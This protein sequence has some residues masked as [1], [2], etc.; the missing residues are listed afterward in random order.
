LILGGWVR[1]MFRVAALLAFGAAGVPAGAVSLL[2]SMQPLDAS[3]GGGALMS[4]VVRADGE[5]LAGQDGQGDVRSRR[6]EGWRVPLA[7]EPADGRSPVDADFRARGPGYTVHVGSGGA[8][9]ALQAPEARGAVASGDAVGGPSERR[10]SRSAV[11]DSGWVRVQFAGAAER[12]GFV[13]EAPVSGRIHR[14]IGSDPARWQRNLQP[15]GRIRYRDVYPGIDVAYYGNGRELE[16][17]LI[18]APGVSP[19]AARV[20]FD[21]VKS[22]SVDAE[23]H[24]R[25]DTGSAVLVQR[26]PVAY[27]DGPRGRVRVEAAYRRHEDGTVGFEMGAVD[28]RLPLV[29]DPVLSYATLVGG[30]G[31]DACWDVAV[32]AAGAAYVVGETESLNFSGTSIASTN[33]LLAGYQGGLSGVAGDAFVGKLAPDGSA[34]EWLTYLG[35]SDLETAFSVGVASN[36]EP[37]V[38]GFTSSTNFPLAAGGYLR[39]L[40]GA[41]NGFTARKPLSGF[42]ARLT[43]DGSGMVAST[44]F[45]GSGEDQVLEIGLLPDGSIAAVGSTASTNL[46]VTAGAP[47][48]AFGG[49]VDGFVARFTP[50]LSGLLF[51]TYIGGTVRDSAEGLAIDAGAGVLHVTGITVSTNFPVVAAWQSTNHGLADGF[52][53]GYRVA[54]G[55]QI[56]ATYLGG[57]NTDY[58]Y[59]AAVTASGAVWVTGETFS[60][61]FAGMTGIQST[62]AGGGDGF[63]LRIAG[64]GLGAEYGTF[65]G[66]QFEDVL[67]DVAVD[68]LGAVHFSGIS[69][70]SVFTGISTN[71][72]LRA[73][74]AGVGDMMLVRL[75]P[76]GTLN[77]SFYGGLGDDLAYAVAA[78][79]AGNAYYAGR[80][81]SVAFPVSGTNVAQSLY[82]GGLG[83]GFVMKI[84]ESPVLAAAPTAGGGVALSW[85]APNQGFVLESAA[86]SSPLA[87]WTVETAPMAS[88]AGRH[89]VRL[90]VASSNQ[91]FRLRWNR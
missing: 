68:A 1:P 11:G 83:D 3:P 43:A 52:L 71:T 18:V 88:E 29:I 13:V 6:V 89:V 39:V 81:R 35:G 82:G 40:P 53:A 33:P 87:V 80:V 10:G 2:T 54:D 44:L 37:V 28:A 72:S 74:N 26:R 78:D 76:D 55:S 69:F 7:F 51:S 38:G 27:Q 20:R 21:G 12:A 15:H 4:A 32:D 86:D 46:P 50:D 77:S 66:G 90:P 65:L 36:G 42:V 57:E 30:I 9:I 67:W 16:Y 5:V 58:A 61:N 23:G 56:Y 25:L 17:D 48:P 62:N 75:A 64:D 34:F 59:R 84:S 41:T 8:L 31:Y 22:V 19:D 91:V 60:T 73:T 85:A 24:L 14:L 49:V 70:S 63:A 79:A 47:Q 45:G